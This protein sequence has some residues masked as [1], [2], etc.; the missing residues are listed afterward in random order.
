[1]TDTSIDPQTGDIGARHRALADQTGYQITQTLSQGDVTSI[2]RAKGPEGEVVL[3]WLDAPYP[4]FDQLAML[5]NEHDIMS[6]VDH[7]GV[8][9]SKGLHEVGNGLVLVLE[10]VAGGPVGDAFGG[11]AVP[12]KEFF[13][14]AIQIADALK[15]VHGAGII[16]K[17]LNP[18]NILFDQLNQQIK[19]IDFGIATTI[20]SQRPSARGV[21]LMQGT[22]AYMSPE[23]TGRIN[24]AIDDRT[25]MYSL[26]ATFYA[27][28]TGRPPFES[29]DPLDVIHGHLARVPQ[30]PS[31]H[32]G[33]PD[34]LSQIVMK[35][36]S[37]DAEDRYQTAAGLLHDL[38]TCE[39]QLR[40]TYSVNNFELATKDHS[41]RSQMPERVYGR[42]TEIRLLQD[43]FNRVSTGTCEVFLVAG[44]S[45]VGKSL[46]V[47]EVQR[48]LIEG[49]GSFVEGKF[50]QYQR[51]TPYSALVDAFEDLIK[52]LIVKDDVA[53]WKRR[54]TASLGANLGVITDMIPGLTAIVGDVP[55]VPEV[56]AVEARNRLTLA[57]QQ[58]V[59]VLANRDHPVV[60]FIDDLQ[61][62][63]Q[64]SLDLLQNILTDTQGQYFYLIGCYRDN[65]V[66]ADHPMVATFEA[67]QPVN[68]V[69][70][71]T[72][73]PLG[74]NTIREILLDTFVARSDGANQL[75]EILMKKTDG[76]PFFLNEFLRTLHE[77][78]HLVF[79][80]DLGEWTWNAALI[81]AME[82]TDNVSDL[83]AARLERL[84]GETMNILRL[85]ACVGTHSS[86]DQLAAKLDLDR[87]EL[88][89]R[90]EPAL[91]EGVMLLAE[92]AS[93]GQ[94]RFSFSHDRVRHAA[95]SK[96][97]QGEQWEMHLRIGRHLLETLPEDEK[98]RRLFDI[99]DQL[100]TG[101]E[102]IYD[103]DEQRALARLNLD[104]CRRAKSAAAFGTALK[105]IQVAMELM[106]DNV[107]ERHPDIAKDLYLERGE[108]EFLNGHFEEADKHLLFLIE[109]A[110]DPM[111]AHAAYN[112]LIAAT[113]ARGQF[114][115]SIAIGI[116]ALDKLGI[117]FLKGNDEIGQ[118]I[119][120]ELGQIQQHLQEM[121]IDSLIDLPEMTDPKLA[122]AIQL[123]VSMTSTS[124]IGGPELYPL[125][126]AKQIN[127]SIEHGNAPASSI[128]YSSYG[129]LNSPG[130][131]SDIDTSYAFGDLALR[132]SDRQAIRENA[133]NVDFVFGTFISHWRN[134][135][136]ESV[137]YLARAF[138]AALEA[139]NFEYVRYT[140]TFEAFYN[141]LQWNDL[142][143]A[144]AST[145]KRLDTLSKIRLNDS[146][147]AFR[148]ANQL[149]LT[150]TG[151][152]GSD[153]DPYQMVGPDFDEHAAEAEW[154][155][156]N[157]FLSLSCLYVSRII[158]SN[159]Y[160]RDAETLEL[161]EAAKP[162]L[163]ASTGTFL[164]AEFTFCRALALTA[165]YAASDEA[166]KAAHLEQLNEDMATLTVWA[167]KS[168]QNFE[169]RVLILQAEMGALGIGETEQGFEQTIKLYEQAGKR[170]REG[171]FLLHEG[172]AYERAAA[173]CE[174]MDLE[175]LA[176]SFLQ[177]SVYAFDRMSAAP[178]ADMLRARLDGPA[179]TTRRRTT[180]DRTVLAT[181]SQ[182]LDLERESFF[183][184]SQAISGAIRME[185][186]LGELIKILIESAGA[187]RCA[188]IKVED[189]ELTVVAQSSSADSPVQIGD[190]PLDGI[191]W[192]HGPVVRYAPQT[193][194]PVVLDDAQAE[195]RFKDV[196]GVKTM[197]SRSILCLPIMERGKIKHLMY[198]SNDLSAGAFTA[199]RVESVNLLS[200]Q[201]ATSMANAELYESLEDKVAE[202][203]NQLEAR[204][205]F[206]RKEFGRYMSDEVAENLLD[207]PK[208][209]TAGGEQRNVTILMADL[210]GFTAMA[211]RMEAR[212]VVRVINNFLSEMTKV[213][214]RHNGTINDFIGDAI[215][216]IFG[217]PDEREDDAE[218]AMACAIDMQIAMDAVN[219]R[220]VK[221][222]LP[223]VS[224]GV[225][226]HT[227]QVVVGNLG[228]EDRVKFGVI[229]QTVNLAS[230]VESYTV[231]G[232][233]LASQ[234]TLKAAVDA[235]VV[236]GRD[237]TIHPK[238]SPEPLNIVEV[239]A[240]KGRYDL[241]L[242]D[243]GGEMVAV[244]E[245]FDVTYT[246][247][248]GKVASG[249]PN[250]AKLL[251]VSAQG[252]AVL[253][254]TEPLTLF[255]N[256]RVGL[257]GGSLAAPVQNLYAKVLAEV[258]PQ[259]Y[260]VRFTSISEELTDLLT[261]LAGKAE[262]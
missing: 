229:G 241:T 24:R 63:D 46:L 211:D 135:L 236:T 10:N 170:A 61:W 230:R 47:K 190:E 159:L 13:T 203:T 254:V 155:Q 185:D 27:L 52:Q 157:D 121:E 44:T 223:R 195:G 16:H 188:V 73:Q 145:A 85:A 125:I 260:E 128:A 65:E 164:L 158:I 245:T 17:D 143:S 87:M 184:A 101:R 191:D 180:M 255:S 123:L 151:A 149:A 213:I 68:R 84:P 175:R 251:S 167:E 71:L 163:V 205:Q 160:R 227:G 5:R 69:E 249:G 136:A 244:T 6:R 148:L 64:A 243:A 256:L 60:L 88:R 258:E 89:R 206:I 189:E 77:S 168:P 4:T 25:D 45:G 117:T 124:F 9:R 37:K 96:M 56:G 48:P 183:R 226:L 36:L 252:G 204:N 100:N 147:G 70:R 176:T 115:K 142:S 118:A 178:K 95:Y 182:R 193:R 108:C 144:Q 103:R 146:S 102:G 51:E 81:A 91:R 42:D 250:Y 238:G 122:A 110:T 120:A 228:S 169:H 235:D 66:G 141:V 30:K 152:E 247:I 219:E 21:D 172:I 257:S 20:P 72:L 40:E 28:L 93:V 35:L 161:I 76:N 171:G 209:L 239:T 18:Q 33:M 94:S 218:R 242:P 179:A 111:D 237:I 55:P 216:A 150:L 173:F 39:R 194:A 12:I 232:Q 1:M 126:V 114:A 82:T 187:E 177:D 58:F 14:I 8:L 192:L 34:I 220:N 92:D 57:F 74:E 140:A 210:R 98:A 99:A 43:G 109:N 38:E 197:R 19:I 67:I 112:V 262:T 131:L 134:H 129:V 62:A 181:H 156:G 253:Q 231:G 133:V 214:Q 259:K 165:T 137:T 23:Q 11:N 217:A 233:V 246:E 86:E 31:E 207:D 104:A 22:I 132:M 202:R 130:G 221:F 105:H 50:D 116:E 78:G 119:G 41:A 199:G 212:A 240:V 186:L 15:A 139:G 196:P 49:N 166:T 153:A 154:K 26:G 261:R 224:M 127:L 248:D 3:K 201:V 215:L 208:G 97:T 234:A 162:F 32:V 2:H 106:G 80:E 113:N 7:P 83:T 29:D 225:G 54:L 198:L 222:G 90:L 79:D 53:R 138:A 174:G 75:A 59:W 107:W 200:G